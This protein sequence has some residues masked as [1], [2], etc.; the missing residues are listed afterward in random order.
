MSL[1]FGKGVNAH[2]SN[3]ATIID[4]FH[5]IKHANEAVDTVRKEKVR[6]NSLLK[7]FR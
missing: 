4:K 5:V 3:A 1:G 6:T 7:C 2:F